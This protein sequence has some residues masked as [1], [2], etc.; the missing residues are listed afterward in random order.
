M[1]VVSI[2]CL[3]EKFNKDHISFESI[4]QY[5]GVDCYLGIAQNRINMPE[6][7]SIEIGRPVY[8]VSR[9]DI[10]GLLRILKWGYQ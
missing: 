2:Y 1:L 3:R 4:I 9:E 7:S 8:K 10:G 6:P 5:I